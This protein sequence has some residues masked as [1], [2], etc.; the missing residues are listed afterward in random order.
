M[1]NLLIVF[2]LILFIISCK[3]DDNTNY[4]DP[5][6][7]DK[8][9]FSSGDLEKGFIS[10]EKNGL[11]W[12]ASAEGILYMSV[13]PISGLRLA[14]SAYT[15]NTKGAEREL[16]SFNNIPLKLKKYIPSSDK[17]S[18]VHFNFGRL[19]SDGDVI[20]ALPRMIIDDT[21]SSNYFEVTRL[22]TVAKILEARFDV[23]LR[24]D[25]TASFYK[26][27]KMRFS[28]GLIQVKLRRE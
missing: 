6:Y 28:S 24:S 16:L 23:S 10:A 18:D 17:D 19:A 8:T 12:K 13:P 14:A 7:S 22:D 5:L 11:E 2:V 27:E 21:V 20:A 26:D 3:K 15:F 1:K 4:D 9:I 25:K